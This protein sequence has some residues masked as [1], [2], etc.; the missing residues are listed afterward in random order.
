M[1]PSTQPSW[2]LE[3]ISELNAQITVTVSSQLQSLMVFKLC[4]E[5]ISLQQLLATN[6][7]GLMSVRICA[8][9]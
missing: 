7:S 1:L 4:F 9:L 6:L 5:L 2:Q 3:M 8:A